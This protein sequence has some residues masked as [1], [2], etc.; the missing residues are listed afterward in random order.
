VH[1]NCEDVRNL[2]IGLEKLRMGTLSAV[3]FERNALMTQPFLDLEV[4]ATRRVFIFSP[5][6]FI[7]SYVELGCQPDPF[8]RLQISLKSGPNSNTEL[9]ES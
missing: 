9:D 3:K 7:G 5:G 6:L 8:R 2:L 1:H 4:E